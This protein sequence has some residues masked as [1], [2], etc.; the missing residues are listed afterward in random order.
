MVGAPGFFF[1]AL[2]AGILLW[3]IP[4]WILAYVA[5]ARGRSPWI[6][7]LGVF[8]LVGLIAGLLVLIAL[9]PR[10]NGAEA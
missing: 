9:P 5:N 8:G 7:A 4:I 3:V 1:L 10:N 2:L 6:G